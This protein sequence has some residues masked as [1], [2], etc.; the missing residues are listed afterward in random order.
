MLE[1]NIPGF[2]LLNLEHLVSDFTG[3]ISVGGTL[4][5]GIREKLNEIALFLKVHI[6]TADTFEKACAELEGIIVNMP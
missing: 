5:P 4:L 1:I 2:G 3:T 6:L